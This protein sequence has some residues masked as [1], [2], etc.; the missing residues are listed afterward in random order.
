MKRYH[1][2]A[3]GLFVTGL[4]LLTAIQTGD[5][6]KGDF[7]R[8]TFDR[9]KHYSAVL[10]Q[11]G[12]VDLDADWNEQAA[13]ETYQHRI[14]GQ[15]LIGGSGV[16][17][18]EGGFGICFDRHDELTISAGRFYVDGILCESEELTRYAAQ[19]DYPD[20]SPLEPEE[21]RRDLVYLDVWD[22]HIT[23]L[24]D[25]DLSC[26]PLGAADAATRVR[27]VSQVKIE[28]GECDI[29]AVEEK[30]ERTCRLSSGGTYS[31]FEN[32]LYRVEIHES[33]TASPTFKWSRDNGSVACAIASFDAANPRLV[34]LGADCILSE[35]N[36]GALVEVLGDQ[37]ELLQRPGV[38]ARVVSVDLA[39]QTLLLDRDVSAAAEEVHPKV[40]RWDGIGAVVEGSWI[41]LEGGVEI[42]FSPGGTYRAGDYWHIEARTG[43]GTITQLNEAPPQGIQHHYAALAVIAWERQGDSITPVVEDLRAPFRS[44]TD[45]ER[46]LEALRQFCREVLE[47][48]STSTSAGGKAVPSGTDLIPKD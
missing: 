17:V 6:M 27:P 37:S 47:W 14:R 34:A 41:A 28:R 16:P 13:I 31:G 25:P 46:E 2:R 48:I 45:M 35:F 19:P 10:K 43:S 20:P 18:E 38:L 40:R 26:P 23:A 7:S 12:R 21:G 8:W 11:Q 33:D 5:A 15:D 3:A 30:A 36:A 4:A 44:L 1:R 22:R 29:A 42:C 24:E 39:G 32:E 9:A